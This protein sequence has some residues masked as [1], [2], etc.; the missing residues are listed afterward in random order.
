MAEYVNRD[1]AIRAICENCI[2]FKTCQRDYD[3]C[4][5]LLPIIQFPAADVV[6]VVRCRDCKHWG[7]TLAPEDLAR[8]KTEQ[9]N[10][11]VCDLWM[12][13]GFTPDDYCSFAERAENGSNDPD[14][15]PVC[16]NMI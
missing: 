13:D 15:Y 2:E 6:E 14:E 10:D 3:L 12:S 16:F 1:E 9:D 11:L 4:D 7:K 5:D 8:A